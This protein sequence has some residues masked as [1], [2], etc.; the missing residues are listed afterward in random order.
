MKLITK[1]NKTC[2]TCTI[3]G[4]VVGLIVVGVYFAID[5]NFTKVKTVQTAN[6]AIRGT[7][8]TSFRK[9]VDYFAFRGIPYAKPPVGAL[10]LKVCVTLGYGHDYVVGIFSRQVDAP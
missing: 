1:V 4:V 3:L 8:Q 2:V 9:N 7:R 5:F 6:G 10:R